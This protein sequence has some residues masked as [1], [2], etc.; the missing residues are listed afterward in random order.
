MKDI[1]LVMCSILLL[2]TFC[3]KKE[4]TTQ[5]ANGYSANS[6]NLCECPPGSIDAYGQCLINDG[7]VLFGT[8]EGCPCQQDSLLLVILGRTNVLN[9]E[10][11]LQL[12]IQYV[13]KDGILGNTGF[14]F[15][16]T[17]F[18][19]DSLVPTVFSLNTYCNID[20]WQYQKQVTG[21]IYGNDSLVF[22]FTFERPD[23]NG[24]GKFITAP[25]SCRM[26]V[27]N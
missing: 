9:S 21:R 16:P 8:S 14:D 6:E 27:R 15:I 25:D 18:G 12:N 13:N 1:F 20:S 3:K 7:D 24:S 11:H 26:V 23:P 10:G 22:N 2:F 4:D 19:Y 5:C 17:N